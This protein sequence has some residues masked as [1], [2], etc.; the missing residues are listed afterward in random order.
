MAS[1]SLDDKE[2]ELFRKAVGSV[3]PVRSNQRTPDGEKK[4]IF[5][6]RRESPEL[7]PEPSG[8][9]DVTMYQTLSYVASGINRKVLK[10]LRSGFFGIDA[11]LDLHGLS[12]NQA[13]SALQRFLRQA[14]R[15]RLLCVH[16]IHGK[17]YRS[18]ENLPILKNSLNG[19]L[20]QHNE[21][22]AFCSSRQ[23][24][25][26]SGALYVLLHQRD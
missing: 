11:E 2:R 24:D 8:L 25:G 3:R 9:A 6:R 14:V 19:W 21:V 18:S 23:R 13:Q 1:K 7:P 20:R 17:G 15:E 4:P 26:G 16:I 5:R 10:K 12:V 22:L